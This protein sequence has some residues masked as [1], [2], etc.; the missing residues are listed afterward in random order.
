MLDTNASRGDSETSVSEG[1]TGTAPIHFCIDGCFYSAIDGDRQQ[2]TQLG[3]PAAGIRFIPIP[4]DHTFPKADEKAFQQAVQCTLCLQFGHSNMECV[5]QCALC[6]ARMHTTA[7]Y[8]YN[9]LA[10]RNA[11]AVQTVQP[12]PVHHQGQRANSRFNHGNRGGPQFQHR[13]WPHR[14]NLVNLD[15]KRPTSARR[16]DR[17]PD[18][19]S[20]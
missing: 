20:A 8:E 11:P 17:C 2:S 6:Q 15:K 4:R 12:V 13:G 19:L 5:L 18:V 16:M 9:L 3:S 7:T 14:S 1:F 10:R